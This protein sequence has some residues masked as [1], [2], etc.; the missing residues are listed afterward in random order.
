MQ[1]CCF[2]PGKASLVFAGTAVGSVVLW[3]LRE[4]GRN[5]YRLK[6]GQDEWTFRQPTFSTGMFPSHGWC[7]PCHVSGQLISPTLHVFTNLVLSAFVLIF[8]SVIM[9]LFMLQSQENGCQ[10]ALNN[11]HSCLLSVFL[12]NTDTDW[13]SVDILSLVT[14]STQMQWCPAQAIPHLWHL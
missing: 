4:Q 11:K 5:H 9:F 10:Q 12:R 2:S 13:K 1:C 8:H 7:F 14:L 3:D 6:I